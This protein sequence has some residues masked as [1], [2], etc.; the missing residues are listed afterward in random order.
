[1]KSR[2]RVVAQFDA[3][4]GPGPGSVTIDR[5]TAIVE[6]RPRRRRRVY[7][8][9]LSTVATMICRAIIVAELRERRSSRRR[10]R[11]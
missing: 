10:G 9:P 8:L 5:T 4:G 7:A 11:R 3:A 1:M 6:V 2:F